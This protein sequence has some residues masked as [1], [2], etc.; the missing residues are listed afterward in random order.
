MTTGKWY[1]PSGRSIQKPRKKGT[2]LPDTTESDSA[3]RARPAFH[4]DG[5]R[6]VY[7]GGGITP[8]VV[9]QP[10]TASTAEQQLLRALAPKSQ[11]TH[12]TLYGYAL[13]LKKSV[14]PDFKVSDSWRDTLYT[15]LTAAG[16][17]VDRAKFVAG[18]RVIDRMLEERVASLAFGDS[19][20][21]RRAIPEDQQL[22]RAIAML[23][24]RRSQAEVLA[25][26]GR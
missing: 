2:L 4:S 19:A 17:A 14:R 12:A 5:G 15:R 7:G 16:V 8:D 22:L 6:V 23:H 24:G 11:Q 18:E 20:A 25:A 3:R 9:V 13:E 21:F 26:A 1:T 10:D